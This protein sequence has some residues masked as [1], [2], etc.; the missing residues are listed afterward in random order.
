M[1]LPMLHLF[2]LLLTSSSLQYENRSTGC[3]FCLWLVTLSCWVLYAT[4]WSPLS[5]FCDNVSWVRHK[6]IIFLTFIS[7]VVLYIKPF[8]VSCAQKIKSSNTCTC[9][10]FA[11]TVKMVCQMVS[12]KT[13]IWHLNCHL[14]WTL[15]LHVKILNIQ[16]TQTHK[17]LI[18]LHLT[19]TKT[20]TSNK[21]V[22]NYIYS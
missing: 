7:L 20:N 2:V 6:R 10:A 12:C 3:S 18:S 11:Y 22:L 4:C 13:V 17:L 14:H 1:Y 8:I 5:M 15:T 16:P 21:S 9:H 19:A